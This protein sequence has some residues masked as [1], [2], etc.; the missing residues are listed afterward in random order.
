MLRHIFYNNIRASD[1]AFR[2]I[3]AFFTEKRLSIYKSQIRPQ[4]KLRYVVGI[5]D[6]HNISQFDLGADLAFPRQ[7]QLR[8][9]SCSARTSCG[10]SAHDPKGLRLNS[11]FV[12]ATEVKIRTRGTAVDP[13]MK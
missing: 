8:A 10:R 9:P 11:D 4:V 7:P 5:V 6:P 2:P 3:Q 13:G 12:F 1:Q